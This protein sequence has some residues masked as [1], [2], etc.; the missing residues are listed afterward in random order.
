MMKNRIKNHQPSKPI[1]TTFMEL[2][3]ELS[4]ITKDDA[5]VVAAVKSIFS[6]YKVRFTRTLAPVRLVGAEPKPRELRRA[7]LGRRSSALA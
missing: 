1:K 4:S 5:L 6:S 7:N 2:L 3:D